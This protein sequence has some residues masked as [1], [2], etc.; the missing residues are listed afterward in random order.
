MIPGAEQ[1][2]MGLAGVPIKAVGTGEKLENLEDFHPERV[3]GR[4]LG[5]EML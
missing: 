1:P 5:R 4:I 2:V 3:A